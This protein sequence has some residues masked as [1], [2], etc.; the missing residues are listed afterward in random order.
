MKLPKPSPDL[1]RQV[2]AVER[3]DDGG[4]RFWAGDRDWFV[5]HHEPRRV[6]RFVYP[7][8]ALRTFERFYLGRG[9]NA[10]TVQVTHVGILPGVLCVCG[11]LVFRSEEQARIGLRDA[12]AARYRDLSATTLI[13]RRVYECDV[14]SRTWHLTKLDEDDLR[15]R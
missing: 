8:R 1:L 9:W 3:T 15:R 12:Q 5:L 11:K 6:I 13:E 2:W 14:S 7:D 10:P 4:G